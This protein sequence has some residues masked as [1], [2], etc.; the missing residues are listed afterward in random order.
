M[1]KIFFDVGMSLDGFI[2][3]LNGGPKNPL[4]DEGLKIHGWV[5]PLKSFKEHL[6][7]PGKGIENRDNELVEHVLGRTGAYI[8][9]KRMFDEGEVSWPENA[10][11]R[12]PVF[13]LTHQSREP[14]ERKGGTTFYFI[15][16]GI[17][18]ALNKA[19]DAAG[20]KDIRIS[21]GADVIQQYLNAE[22]IDEFT[23]HYSPVILG[24]GVRL[25]DNI[26]NKKLSA[27]IKEVI[28]SPQ[29]THL[30]YNL[31]RG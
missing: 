13:V 30:F 4:G 31:R 7:L 24:S 11:F 16:D 15:N 14:W 17:Q 5:F 6:G 23:I 20:N 22:L 18:S 1:S 8:M 25:F 10:P 26:D 19:K 9:G 27:K 3:G 21:G 2:A 29:I 28:S 12:A